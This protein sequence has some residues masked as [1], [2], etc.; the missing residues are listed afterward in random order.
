MTKEITK[1][2]ILQQIQDKFKLRELAPETFRFSEEVLPVY[3][4]EQ[5]LLTWEVLE[6]TM[7]ITGTGSFVFFA[8]P[9]NERWTL[10]SYYVTFLMTGAI[11][12][13]GLFIY[14]RPPGT[15]VSIF[16]DMIKGQEVSYLVVLPCPVVLDPGN[17][18][19]YSIDTYV[20][21][22]E[23]TIRIDVQREEIR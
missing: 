5:H 15:T 10:R 22:Q 17:Q 6:K 4:I 18:L 20:S 23:L 1:A 13:T 9:D 21:T 3:N 11:K 2:F 19:L 12:G 8:V 7:S 16:L 14:N